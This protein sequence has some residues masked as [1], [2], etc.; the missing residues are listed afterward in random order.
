MRP[1]L[2]PGFVAAMFIVLACLPLAAAR[3][4][5]IEPAGP[6]QELATGLGM[7][8]AAL[9]L[10]QFLSSGRYEL[11]SARLGIDR[12]MGFHRISAFA[13]I[14]FAVLHPLAYVLATAVVDPDAAW[15][16]LTA[17]VASPRL[18]SG[19]IALIGTA[20]LILFAVFREHWK[21]RY[22]TW[23]AMHS[24]IAVAITVLVLHHA[25][26]V[27]TYSAEKPVGIVWAVL[28]FLALVAITT[29]YVVRPWR[30]LR[31]RW[32]VTRAAPS[33]SGSW[34]IALRGPDETHFNFEPGQ[35][36]WISIAPHK[37]PFHDHPFSIA[38]SPAD[39]PELRL[40]V[41]ASGD[42]TCTFGRIVAGTP[43]A[44]DGPHGSFVLD[45]GTP[46]VLFVAG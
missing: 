8:A 29:V 44:I 31:E 13:L 6:L 19:L 9:I 36:V 38:S 23:R 30:M 2:P 7:M 20:G 11:F 42:C 3:W 28:A 32:V 21:V 40:I 18:R 4:S 33:G 34:E 39:L 37:P 16:R 22:E 41:R 14:A 5:G 45:A 27:G 12:M 25:M 46:R 10:L 1:G 26:T 43:V 17:M 15:S 24:I 35:F